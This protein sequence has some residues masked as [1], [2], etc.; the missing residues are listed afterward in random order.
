[1]SFHALRHTA[2]TFA[3][4]D[5]Q[6]AHVVAAMLAMPVMPATH[7]LNAHL[8][9]ASTE[10]LIDAIDARYGPRLRVLPRRYWPS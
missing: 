2:A 10:A 9:H 3:L 4:Q 5:S 1:M 8:T 7:P 6:P